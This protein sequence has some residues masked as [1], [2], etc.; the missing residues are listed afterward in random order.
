MMSNAVFSRRAAMT[1]GTTTPPH[2]RGRLQ[3]IVRPSARAE[4]D[5]HRQA[6]RSTKPPWRFDE[7][8]RPARPRP[9]RLHAGAVRSEA[10]APAMLD[11][12]VAHAETR[13]G[14][15]EPGYAPSVRSSRNRATHEAL[16]RLRAAY[17][18]QPRHAC[19]RRPGTSAARCSGNRCAKRDVAG[20]REPSS[21]NL[22]A[23]GLTP[24][25]A[26]ARR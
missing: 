14:G 12:Y 4:A 13:A 24:C 11:D 22:H 8:R 2:P 19:P 9:P 7:A 23:R 18:G 5:E 15:Y 21:R 10:C 6:Q 17:G 3:H 26:A 25:S 1:H 16:D 20:S